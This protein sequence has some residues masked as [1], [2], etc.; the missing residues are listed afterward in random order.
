MAQLETVTVQYVNPAKPGKKTGSI[1][2]TDGRYI[3]VWPDKLDQFEQNGTYSILT[4]QREFNGKTYYSLK[5]MAD[6]A[7][8][9]KTNGAAPTP[10]REATPLKPVPLAPRET[11]ARDAERMFVCSLLNAAIQANQ[12]EVGGPE[13]GSVVQALRQTWQQTFGKDNGGPSF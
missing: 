9:P 5:G 8:A 4:E 1:K 7:P 6:S 13:L 11:S 2:V 3:D 10:A 12:I